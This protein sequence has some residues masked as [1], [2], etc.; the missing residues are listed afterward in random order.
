MDPVTAFSFVAGILQV[1]D[2]SF[3]ALSTCREIYR[4]GSLSEN[5]STEETAQHLAKSTGRLNV[6]MQNTPNAQSLACTDIL[7]ISRKCSKTAEE[8]LMELEK[9]RVRSEGSR[10]EAIVKGFHTIRRKKFLKESQAKLDSYQ[11]IMDTRILVQLNASSIQQVKHFHSLDQD[12]KDLAVALEQ[13]RNTV[14]QLI[15][16]QTLKL[17]AHIDHQFDDQ[18]QRSK[19]LEAQQEFK[20]S[21]FFPEIFSRQENICIAHEGTYQWIFDFEVR[22]KVAGKASWS[23]FADWVKCGKSN[24]G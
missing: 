21:L 5:R 8:L 13:G 19:R 4:D 18:A 23:S 3:K 24:S 14:R 11:R 22:D 12:V 17:Q 15:T 16:D 2:I 20:N 10:R 1:V 6:T 9:L 7:D